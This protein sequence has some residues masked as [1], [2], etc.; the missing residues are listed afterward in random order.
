MGWARWMH[1]EIEHATFVL[2]VCTDVY[3]RR[4]EGKEEPGRGLGANREGLII[5]NNIYEHGGKNDKFI[6]VLVHS[7]DGQFVPYFLRPYQYESVETDEGYDALYRRLTHQPVVEKPVIGKLRALPPCSTGMVRPI[8]SPPEAP[9]GDSTDPA[10]RDAIRARKKKKPVLDLEGLDQR[11]QESG[12]EQAHKTSRRTRLALLGAVVLLVLLGLV[13]AYSVKKPGGGRDSTSA[14]SSPKRPLAAA[15]TNPPAGIKPSSRGQDSP[16]VPSQARRENVNP[17]PR[18]IQKT[19]ACADMHALM[20]EVR[21]T[22]SKADNFRTEGGI[23]FSDEPSAKGD[24]WAESDTWKTKLSPQEGTLCRQIVSFTESQDGR[25]VAS[26]AATLW[27]LRSG[28][29]T[30]FQTTFRP[31]N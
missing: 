7:C 2:V 23:S 28:K 31:K 3:K 22:Y 21:H 5:D 1:E 10:E 25:L 4:A 17:R 19:A 20:R 15:K 29:W 18:T 12:E 24:P 27:V 9:L 8:H 11:S 26:E 14:P 6:P 16:K 30:F 13:V